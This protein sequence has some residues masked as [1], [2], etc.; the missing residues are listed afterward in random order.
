MYTNRW[1]NLV[2]RRQIKETDGEGE[3]VGHMM[4]LAASEQD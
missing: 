3:T 4:I 2:Y 1:G